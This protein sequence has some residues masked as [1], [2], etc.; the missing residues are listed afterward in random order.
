MSPEQEQKF[1]DRLAAE[2]EAPVDPRFTERLAAEQAE[3][4]EK[5]VNPVGSIF[6][7]SGAALGIGRI[8]NA[9]E[10]GADVDVARLAKEFNIPPDVV[11]KGQNA[12]INYIRSMHTG[13]I[14]YVGGESFK[15]AHALTEKA[16]DMAK[17]APPGFKY[18][19][20]AQQYIPENEY[21]QRAAARAKAQQKSKPIATRVVERYPS[22]GRASLGAQNVLR[23]G[24]PPFVG[25]TVVGGFGG[26]S[27]AEAYNRALQGDVP[28]A[29]ISGTGAVGALSSLSRNPKLR[30]LGILGMGASAAANQM[31]DS[32]TPEK[33]LTE[34]AKDLGRSIMGFFATGG[35]INKYAKGKA[36]KGGLD[37]LVGKEPPAI[38][39]IKQVSL[40]LSERF[41]YDPKRVARE[42]PEIA[43]PKMTTDPKTGKTFPQKDLSQEAIAVQKARQAAQKEIDQGMMGRPFFDITKREYVDPSNYPLPGRTLTSQVPKKAETVE[44]YRQIAEGPDATERLLSAYRR[45]SEAPMAR[46]WY[47]MKQLEDEFIKELGPDAGRQAFRQRFAEP[48]AATTGGADPTSNLMMTA[49]SNYMDT[50]G[51]TLPTSAFELPFPVGGRFVS[52]NMEQA[53][54]YRQSGGIPIDNPKRH[55]FASNFMGYRD[56]PTIDEQMMGLFAPGK[57]APEPGTYGVYEAALN[58]LA[59]REGVNPVN[60]QDVA[61]AGAKNY[62]GKPMMQEINEMIYRTGR[63]TGESAEDVLR[64]FIRGNKPMYGITGL[65]ALGMQETGGVNNPE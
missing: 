32:P 46:D 10:S 28:G 2:S 6:A 33:P 64:G 4:D 12:V 27:G 25:R 20:D 36:V 30:A 16:K 8:L 7:G 59:A 3:L 43:P 53:N 34:S 55:N 44:K 11:A 15:E 51:K 13:D 22:V 9:F 31:Y 23:K 48:M 47:A 5:M 37:L 29:V 62:Q 39:N 57:G 24:A 17:N 52:G 56:R 54:K 18:D 19:P 38:K 42:Y 60:F 26:Y 21:E 58:K 65:G 61:W 14:N 1:R 35:L 40:P 63:I 49:Y 50:A 45:G 41:G